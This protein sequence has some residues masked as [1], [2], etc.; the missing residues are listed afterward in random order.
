MNRF[1]GVISLAL[2][3]VFLFAGSMGASAQ[4]YGPYFESMLQFVQE[5]YYKDLTDEEGLK[6]AL[7]GMLAG[8]DKYSAFYDNH[9]MEAFNSSLNGNYVGIGAGLEKSD[10]HIKITKV[11]EGSP[12]EK[13]GILEGDLI[14]AVNGVSVFDKDAETVAT[15]I[16]GDAGTTVRIT[17]IRENLTKEFSIVRGTV[18]INPVMSRIEG[19]NAYIRIDSFGAGTAAKFNKAM[20]EVDKNSIRKIIL[21]LRG[22]PGGYVDEATAVAEKLMPPGIITTLDYKSDVMTDQVY[23]SNETHPDYIVAVLVDEG[24]ASASEILAG[25]LEDAGNGFLIGQNTYGKGVFQNLF[26]VL[27]PEAYEKYNKL[28]GEKFVT[29]IQWL[30]YDGVFPKQDEILGTVK[31]TT[32]HYLT[33]KGRAIDSIGLK[34]AVALPNPTNPN[35]VDLSSINF[36]SNSEPITINIY[37]AEVYNIERVLKAAGYLTTTAD[38]QFDTA[39]QDA[40]KKYQANAKLPVTGTIDVNTRDQLNKTLLELRNKNDPQYTKA[41]EILNWFKN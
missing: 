19:E 6:A 25:A 20:D 28:Y 35:N 26:S 30:N 21:D 32:G 37:D 27:T 1:K 31:L 14:T 17:I 4:E 13:A 40:V 2:I 29:E 11:Y 24:S 16:R 8:L 18:S 39:T 12:A 38:K 5:M 3:I 36:L 34:P 9:E 23:S 10:S 33:P 7:K 22:N 41:V 15:A